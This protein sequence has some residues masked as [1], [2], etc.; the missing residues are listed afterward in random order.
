MTMYAN[1]NVARNATHDAV[2]KVT[3]A[4]GRPRVKGFNRYWTRKAVALLRTVAQNPFIRQK[5][6]SWGKLNENGHGE[7]CANQ[8]LIELLDSLRTDPNPRQTIDKILPV[9]HGEIITM[10]D[11]QRLSFSQ[12]ADRIEQAAGGPEALYAD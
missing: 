4:F 5:R 1:G 6:G 8:V 3:S 9:E 2:R 7:A 11:E 12:I 10:N